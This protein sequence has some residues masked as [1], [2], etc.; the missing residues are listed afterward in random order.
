MGPSG[1]WSDVCPGPDLEPYQ[2]HNSYLYW[3]LS[4]HHHG[5]AGRQVRQPHLGYG[6]SETKTAINLRVY[7]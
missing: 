6:R 4:P 3:G 2:R 7:I 5:A 1:A